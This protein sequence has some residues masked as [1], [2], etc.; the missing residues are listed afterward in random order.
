MDFSKEM[1]EFD[2]FAA[3]DLS[4]FQVFTSGAKDAE[5]TLGNLS[6]FFPFQFFFDL[7]F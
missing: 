3:D 1:E 2:P 7:F 4:F 5:V 6:F